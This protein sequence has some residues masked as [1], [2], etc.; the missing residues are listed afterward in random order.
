MYWKWKEELAVGMLRVGFGKIRM[1]GGGWCYG[2]VDVKQWEDN[3]LSLYVHEASS[4]L[5]RHMILWKERF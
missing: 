2:G 4:D 5:V 1:E 3:D